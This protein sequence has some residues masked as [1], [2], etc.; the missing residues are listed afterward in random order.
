MTERYLKA[1]RVNVRDRARLFEAKAEVSPVSKRR[2][3]STSDD[4]P[5]RNGKSRDTGKAKDTDSVSAQ[6][7][8]PSAP[9][10]AAAATATDKENGCP[11]DTAPKKST[12]NE[13][14]ARVGKKSS[15]TKSKKTSEKTVELSASKATPVPVLDPQPQ[16][17]VDVVVQ[18]V[19]K[20]DTEVEIPPQS[21]Q[22]NTSVIQDTNDSTSPA[23]ESLCE[24]PP[25]P[26]VAT[27]VKSFSLDSGLSEL[28]TRLEEEEAA[29][30]IHPWKPRRQGKKASVRSTA[31]LRY[32]RTITKPQLLSPTPCGAPDGVDKDVVVSQDENSV[33]THSP[34]LSVSPTR[35]S[36]SS[37]LPPSRPTP[38]PAQLSSHQDCL[39]AKQPADECD[40]GSSAAEFG[41]SDGSAGAGSAPYGEI[42]V[43]DDDEGDD[44]E[45]DAPTRIAQLLSSVQKFR[46]EIERCDFEDEGSANGTLVEQG[47]S[48]APSWSGGQ[49]KESTDLPKTLQRE[50]SWSG[51]RRD[52]R[53]QDGAE[54]LAVALNK[55]KQQQHQ[56]VGCQNGEDKNS[57]PPVVV[58][59]RHATAGCSEAIS[60]R[61]VSEAETA[62]EGFRSASASRSTTL[63]L[64]PLTSSS[65][66][67]ASHVVLPG[68]HS[69]N[70]GCWEKRLSPSGRD[71]PLK[72]CLKWPLNEQVSCH[73][74]DSYARYEDNE[75]QLW[76]QHPP[77]TRL[78][79]FRTG[80]RGSSLTPLD[81]GDRS[82]ERRPG[83]LA[84]NVR[85]VE[86]PRPVATSLRPHQNPFLNF[87]HRSE[88]RSILTDF[89]A[90]SEGKISPTSN[91]IQVRARPE[92]PAYLAARRRPTL[93]KAGSEPRRYECGALS[94]GEK[95]EFEFD[96]IEAIL[97]ELD[98]SKFRRGGVANSATGSTS[99]PVSSVPK[100]SGSTAVTLSP[101]FPRRSISHQATSTVPSTGRSYGDK[102]RELRELTEKLRPTI[103]KA[104]RE[105][106]LG[107]STTVTANQFHLPSSLTTRWR[108]NDD[109]T[110]PLNDVRKLPHN[111]RFVF[112]SAS[113]PQVD[114]PT[115][116]DDHPFSSVWLGDN[117]SKERAPYA[118]SGFATL[119]R[120][121]MDGERQYHPLADAH[122]DAGGEILVQ[123]EGLV[124]DPDLTPDYA[125]TYQSVTSS[126]SAP[127]TP[128]LPRRGNA[129][130]RTDSRVHVALTDLRDANTPQPPLLQHGSLDRRKRFRGGGG[131]AGNYEPVKPGG[132][133]RSLT[134][135]PQRRGSA[136]E[137]EVYGS[138]D[139]N[140]LRSYGT[141]ACSPGG[142]MIDDSH[143]SDMRRRRQPQQFPSELSLADSHLSPGEAGYEATFGDV[144]EI[145]TGES[146]G[147]SGNGAN[148]KLTK[149]KHYSDPSG[150]K[151][152]DGLLDL[153]ELM[154][155]CAKSEP[156]LGRDSGSQAGH[157]ADGS[158]VNVT[159]SPRCSSSLV[160]RE[161]T[162]SGVS[163]TLSPSGGSVPRRSAS[164]CSDRETPFERSLGSWD[165]PSEK[166]DA[167][168]PQP[169]RRY[170][171]KRLRG[172]Y[173]EMLEEEMRKSGEKQLQKS[174]AISEELSFLNDLIDSRP[175]SDSAVH[176]V[177]SVPSSPSALRCLD[178]DA[179]RTSIGA[180]TDLEAHRS[181]GSSL[182]C[183]LFL[184]EDKGD[185]VTA[186]NL[187]EELDADS[188]D[189]E[190]QLKRHQVRKIYFYISVSTSFVKF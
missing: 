101:K 159:S 169:Q 65:S 41:K 90:T 27:L 91:K 58:I 42:G 79:P 67:S 103:A 12:T 189:P 81:D 60:P 80:G 32:L 124:A 63:S 120:R 10:A 160:P 98:F 2:G 143:I 136:T 188:E 182:P 149:K 118:Y 61:G 43:R 154:I 174:S 110:R 170:S 86:R 183:P 162:T 57:S 113:V 30:G 130:E 97:G 178:V 161:C 96:D 164:D 108:D 112:R 3:S 34:P 107:A 71:L 131:G 114:D 126:S 187:C 134:Y 35:P 22:T 13:T 123:D 52:R 54:T 142:A 51:Q 72:T 121:R 109:R 23:L 100:F 48:W 38:S 85:S 4:N 135:P 36:P 19:T 47:L 11:T 59:G 89:S 181:N 116:N 44:E 115:D 75:Q 139:S 14:L 156:R 1:P 168:S 141:S 66:S 157:G 94:D 106:D 180:I 153:P 68:P 150:E 190:S 185:D 155:S 55:K 82:M 37:P 184:E 176:H 104:K 95:T 172:P 40:A 140:G 151:N 147:I 46:E 16:T 56:T 25:T 7:Q 119:P 158:D 128:G 15:S 62:L 163:R 64:S 21:A 186:W 92:L 87:D 9:P 70:D 166:R 78:S 138:V 117:S 125:Q 26:S 137:D 50:I 99:A 171:K 88:P 17:K 83:P 8:T 39:V 127:S 144:L 5:L 122:Y 148:G 45:D 173:G 53:N 76:E 77:A 93:K 111:R 84:S 129:Q 33:K 177:P 24:Y 102:L 28:T 145:V 20:P 167:R 175:S 132:G 152:N 105:V 29:N 165:V 69:T 31:Y 6:N 146:D 18:E 73:Y 49:I 179:P 133:T 74:D